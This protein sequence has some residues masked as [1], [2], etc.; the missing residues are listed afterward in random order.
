[1]T[2][3]YAKYKAQMKL[4]YRDLLRK[5]DMMLATFDN[6]GTP[7]VAGKINMLNAVLNRVQQAGYNLGI[8]LHREVVSD[9]GDGSGFTPDQDGAPVHQDA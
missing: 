2:T 5:H 3:D 8:D 1:M 6:D 4:L 9:T 7:M